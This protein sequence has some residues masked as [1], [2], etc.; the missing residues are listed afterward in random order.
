MTLFPVI[1]IISSLFSS[2]DEILV[3]GTRIRDDSTRRETSLFKSEKKTLRAAESGYSLPD[4]LE[5][6][7]SAKI[8]SAGGEGQFSFLRIRGS[9]PQHVKWYIDGVT[10]NSGMSGT[11]NAGLFPTLTFSRVEV[12][13]GITPFS[14]GSPSISG[15]VNLLN[16]SIRTEKLT[17]STSLG[18]YSSWRWGLVYQ[19]PGK[20]PI[21]AAMQYFTSLGNFRYYDNNGTELNTE[22]DSI[23][24]RKNNKAST[25]SML[26]NIPLNLNG[27]SLKTTVLYIRNE[28]GLPGPVTM[29][30]LHT[31]YSSNRINLINTLKTGSSK[32]WI[33]GSISAEYLGEKYTDPFDETG[34]GAQN[35]KNDYYSVRTGINFNHRGKS[36]YSGLYLG[37]L[38]ETVTPVNSLLMD[39]EKSHIRNTIYSG[40]LLRKYLGKVTAQLRMDAFVSSND[41]S[42]ISESSIGGG[43]NLSWKIKKNTV[44]KGNIIRAFRQPVFMELYTNIGALKGNENLKS[45]NGWT[46]DAGISS[47]LPVLSGK[48]ESAVFYQKM[49]NLIVFV[50]NSQFIAVSENIGKSVIYGFE[51]MLNL[52]LPGKI[53]LKTGLMAGRTEN[54]TPDAYNYGKSLPGR[55]AYSFDIKIERKIIFDLW[56]ILPSV[57]VNQTSGAYFD[58]DERRPVP[59]RRYYNANIHVETPWKGVS[60][61]LLVKN[62]EN[63]IS[64]T[65]ERLPVTPS[66][67]YLYTQGRGDWLGYPVPGRTFF[68]TVTVNQ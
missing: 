22:D 26:F 41:S 64:E 46:M 45:E 54:I 12:F 38:F 8:F 7:P 10:V 5:D 36:F 30:A 34:V 49:N 15:G 32:N 20:I 63:R 48:I 52:L 1:L 28:S 11:M 44:L 24:D 53:S 23:H 47:K 16:D 62:I 17:V 2:P 39:L 25:L 18:S 29:E 27:V 31:Y 60:M 35:T 9:Q 33:T 4:L 66:G 58:G 3:F 6:T 59:L 13:R 37:Q 56:R 21:K 65:L 40:A 55:P 67:R 50:P 19:K 68:F 57:S 61:S 43:L 42:E 14:L 51:G